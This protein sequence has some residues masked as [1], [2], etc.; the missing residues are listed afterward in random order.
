MSLRHNLA[1]AALGILASVPACNPYQNFSG[2]YF[3]GAVDATAFAA[4]YLGEL[5]GPP[6]Q[7]GGTIAPRDATVNGAPTFYYFFP[8]AAAQADSPLTIED[9]PIAKAYVFDP[10]ATSPFPDTSRCKGPENYVYDQQKDNYRKNEQNPIF[11]LLPSSGSYI[12]IVQQ[13]PVSSNGVTCQDP[14]SKAAVTSMRTDLTVGAPSGKYLA[15]ALIDPGADVQP[16]LANGLGPIHLGWFNH[17]LT[18][19]LDGGYIPTVDV[20][21]MGD[22]PAHTDFRTQ[23]LVFPTTITAI[24]VDEMTMMETVVPAPGEL[25]A[26]FDILEAAR[27]DA[28][29]SPICEVFS[30]DPDV[31]ADGLPVELKSSI[32]DLTQT[33]L[34]TLAP[35]GDLVYCFQVF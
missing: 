2:E 10:T 7:G 34:A 9:L 20:P 27:G 26:G 25:G 24:E 18:V 16:N 13:V 32:A 33:E 17:Y 1:V 30:Y 14:K 15:W 22:V 8:L 12:P 28:A 19:F 11:E 6:E 29:Y 35:T 31:D 5:P 23:Q 21:E 3:A 4:Q